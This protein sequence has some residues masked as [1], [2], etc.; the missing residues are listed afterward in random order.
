MTIANTISQPAANATTYDAGDVNTPTSDLLTIL[1]DTFNGLRSVE[2]LRFDQLAGHPS[3]PAA[4]KWLTYS[5]SSGLF[6]LTSANVPLQ[7]PLF[8]QPGLFR[9]R[10][11]LTSATPVTTSDVTAATNLY[12][13]PFG[14]NQVSLY[15]STLGNWVLYTFSEITLSLAGKAAD[16]NYD[17]FVYVSAGNVVAELVAW[18]NATTRA[19]A[20]TTQNGVDVKSGAVDRLYVGT[21]RTTATIG[22]CEDSISKRYV[23]NR[24]NAV[25]RFLE[26]KSVTASWTYATNTWR[27]ANANTAAGVKFVQ[28]LSQKAISAR[29]MA[30][31]S[32]T[33]AVGAGCVAVGIDSTILPSGLYFESGPGTAVTD[34]N[35]VLGIYEGV[36]G[37]GWH[38]INWL[39][40]S[41]TGTATFYG[42]TTFINGQSGLQARL[43]A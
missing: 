6:V 21:I 34:L 17:V 27:Q 32:Y 28:G 37:I 7:I 26:F 43:A 41:R 16:T 14:G 22:Q 10:L 11:T 9:G 40:R 1:N 8:A 35:G 39:E 33:T 36:P 42:D 30:S 25:D 3:A 20:L 24:Y 5:L 29:V 31:I 18:T 23:W 2:Q 19:T 38:E 15:N 13:T 4:S 12:V